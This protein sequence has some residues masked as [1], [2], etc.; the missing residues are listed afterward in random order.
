VGGLYGVY[1]SKRQATVKL[2]VLCDTHGLCPQA[3]GLESGKGACFAHQIGKCKGVCAERESAAL[4]LVRLK[5]AMNAQRLQAWPHAGRIGIREHDMQSGRTDIHLFDQWCHLATV[6]DEE[7][8][9][10]VC[11]SRFPLA[12]DLDTYQLLLKRLS[13]ASTTRHNVIHFGSTA[14]AQ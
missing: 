14:H 10:D 8:L 4:H 1:R 7:S 9:S 5:M 2:R 13:A 12:F 11:H 3:L 6:H